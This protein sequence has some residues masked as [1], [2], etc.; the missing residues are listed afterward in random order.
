MVSEILAAKVPTLLCFYPEKCFN[1]K[2][3]NFIGGYPTSA[4]QGFI[5]GL[6]GFTSNQKFHLD[7]TY[8]PGDFQEKGK[9]YGL[10]GHL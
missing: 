2:K 1:P 6:V 8:R 9:M 5:N 3:S 10:R 7:L 4:I